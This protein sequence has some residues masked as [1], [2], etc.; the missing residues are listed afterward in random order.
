MKLRTAAAL[1]SVAALAAC[2]G[3]AGGGS[4]PHGGG[5]G[6]NGTPLAQTAISATDAIGSPL[7]AFATFEK[8][9]FA[10]GSGAV[11]AGVLRA[12]TSPCNAG[13]KYSVPDLTGDAHS[14]Q[15]QYFYDT[16]CTSLARDSVRTFQSTSATSEI[17][18]TSEKLYAYAGSTT[19]PVIAQRDDTTTIN[20]PSFDGNGYPSRA[21][22]YSR[23]SNGFLDVGSTATI[24]SN[25]E[26]IVAPASGPQLSGVGT[27]NAFCSDQAG[28]NAVGI[29]TLGNT[30]GW[31]GMVASG[32]RT[33]NND[34]S[35]TWTGTHV[36]N[37]YIA[38][39][40]SMSV[41][42]GQ[43]NTACPLAAPAYT[44]VGGGT[45]VG[46]HSIPYQATYLRGVLVNLTVTNAQLEGG[47]TLNI[48]TTPAQAPQSDLLISGT[49]S[50]ANGMVA[51]FNMNAFGNGA[52]TIASTG[53]QYTITDWHVR[54]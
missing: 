25:Y 43:L 40:G 51:T 24:L 22:G 4:L 6:G 47:L 39:V 28:F 36:G 21:Q 42:T 35:V 49:L 41:A 50:N 3:G 20:S 30:F 27:V 31:T 12:G 32:T 26:L 38:P 11:G 13:A 5:G 48:S 29:G 10:S 8:T 52:L 14:S 44:V 7:K 46:S 17:V 45:A 16:A 18:H 23:E 19:G 2:S 33:V 1:I 15:T 9:D 54:Q 34:G 37:G 53:N